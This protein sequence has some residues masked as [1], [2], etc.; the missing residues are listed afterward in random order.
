MK[1]ILITGGNGFVGGLIKQYLV[2]NFKILTVG[3]NHA[4]FTWDPL[5][6]THDLPENEAWDG[7]IHLSGVNV[8]SQRWSPSFKKEIYDSR[9]QSTRLLAQWLNNLVS[10]PRW[11]ISASATGFYPDDSSLIQN[12]HSAC[13]TGFL[14]QVCQ[15]WEKETHLIGDMGIRVMKFRIGVV[16]APGGGYMAQMQKLARY[17]ALAPLGWGE[18][19]MPWIQGEDLV[20]AFL[21]GIQNEQIQ[22][23]VNA[24]SPEFATSK[25]LLL[26]MAQVFHSRIWLPPVP[27]FLLK[28]ILGDF[29]QE[30]LTQKKVVPQVLLD[31]GFHWKYPSVKHLSS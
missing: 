10:K 13:G 22:G 11:V 15:D 18:H 6:M 21:W 20:S 31:S 24:V 7:V 27:D 4:D 25:D 17:H 30:L 16:V 12:E 2:Q 28:M 14:S 23:P 5:K 19:F 8:A 9:I 29:S 26:A 3:R 1:K